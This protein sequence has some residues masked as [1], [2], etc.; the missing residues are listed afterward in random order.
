MRCFSILLAL[1]CGIA[2][3]QAQ[4]GDVSN[5]Q[6]NASALSTGTLPAGRMPALTGD[7]TTSAGAVATS[8]TKTGGVAFTGAATAT[9][10]AAGTWTP[11]DA[12]GAALVFTSVSASFTQI[13]NMVFAYA[14]FSYP[15]TADASQALIGG[16]PVT[17]PNQQY[18]RQC[19][20]T[21]SSI[22]G[23]MDIVPNANSTQISPRTLA[24][25]N[26]TNV[27]LSLAALKI[28]CIYPAS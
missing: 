17:V 6:T 11:T 1:W 26:I 21:G 15:A 9:Y 19:S 2:T 20:V 12:S 24:G 14:S 25:A 8:C 18:A 16:L 13:G 28:I 10:V 22:A 7:C 23:G 5:P 27:T 3:A 4:T